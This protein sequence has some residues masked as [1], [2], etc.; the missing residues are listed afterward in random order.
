MYPFFIATSFATAK[1]GN[2]SSAPRRMM[3]KMRY[4]HAMEYYAAL[5]RKDFQTHVTAWMNPEDMM[6]SEISSSQKDEYCGIP[7]I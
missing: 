2:T 7:L 3:N 6:Q 1:G 4:I 5:K